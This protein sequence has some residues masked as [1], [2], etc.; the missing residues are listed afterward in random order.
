MDEHYLLPATRYIKLNTVRAGLVDRPE[1]YPWSSAKAHMACRDDVLVKVAAL[2]DMLGDCG[3]FLSKELPEEEAGL[4][5]SHEP[6][7]RPPGGVSFIDWLEKTSGRILRSQNPAE[8]A[9]KD[10]NK[11]WC[12]WNSSIVWMLV[13]LYPYPHQS[14]ERFRF[15]SPRR[16]SLRQAHPSFDVQ[17]Q[18]AK[19]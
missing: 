8:N 10:Q 5:R 16:V 18:L 1:Q 6:T 9:N 4:L 12:P 3:E 15:L 2:L 14:S 13:H 19:Y 7:G 11:V 17:I